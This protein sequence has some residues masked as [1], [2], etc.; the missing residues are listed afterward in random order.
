MSRYRPPRSTS[1]AI[2]LFG[3]VVNV[4]LTIQVISVCRSLKWESDSEWEGSQRV[5]GVKLV[6]GLLCLYFSAASL[7]SLVG[8]AGVAKVRPS[9]CPHRPDPSP[10]LH[11][12]SQG[13]VA[14]LRFYRDSFIADFV[15]TS[16][17]TLLG[18]YGA[19]QPATRAMVCE[20]LSRQPEFMR[21]LVEMGLNLENCELWFERAVLATVALVVIL[22]VIRVSPSIVP[23]VDRP[24]IIISIPAALSPRNLKLLHPPRPPPTNLLSSPT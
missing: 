12:H 13:K 6:S 8:F 9:V 17:F 1:L 18:V 21:D 4:A 2:T 19:F 15:F 7:V 3:A 11:F 20:E 23:F 16:F 14:Y 5:D 24:T 10:H 22:V